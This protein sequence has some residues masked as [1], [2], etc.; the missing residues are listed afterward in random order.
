MGD[1]LVT[2]GLGK[3][4]VLEE[5]TGHDRLWEVSICRRYG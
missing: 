1:E 2:S 5:Q 4:F 3:G